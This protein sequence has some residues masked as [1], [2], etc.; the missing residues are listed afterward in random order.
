MLLRR[1]E[2]NT[3]LYFT[4]NSVFCLNHNVY[5]ATDVSEF[6]ILKVFILK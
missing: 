2:K 5:A 1:L 6:D 3:S 4:R